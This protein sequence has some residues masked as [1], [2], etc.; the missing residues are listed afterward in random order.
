[1]NSVIII[2]S[3]AAVLLSGCASMNENPNTTKGVG[4]GAAAGGVLGAIVGNNNGIEI[5]IISRSF[6]ETASDFKIKL[7]ASPMPVN[8]TPPSVRK[9]F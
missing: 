7:F 2:I 1:M 6:S 3:A 4:I 5:N 8:C 9:A